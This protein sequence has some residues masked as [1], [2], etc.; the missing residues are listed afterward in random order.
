MIRMTLN[1]EPVAKQR[2]RVGKWGGYTPAKTARFESTIG[3]LARAGMGGQSPM[4]GKLALVVMFYC[5][6]PK[7][8]K[9]SYPRK[10][11][12]DNFIKSFTDACNGIVWVDDTQLACIKAEKRYG[13]PPR[14][15]F[16]VTEMI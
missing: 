12:L 4:P 13:T 8:E 10:S 11:D 14:I 9:H 16:E 3:D 2:A 5:K 6:P 1:L 7:R 15:E